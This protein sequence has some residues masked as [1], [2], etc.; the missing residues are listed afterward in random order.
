M[1]SGRMLLYPVK[2]F[3]LYW[4]NKCQLASIQAGNIGRVIQLGEFWEEERLS[5]M[6]RR[7]D[8]NALLSKI[9]SHVAKHREVLWVN[10]SCKS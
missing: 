10:L 9:P 3:Y 1:C 5:L 4:F 7:Q 8:E 2:I 6:Q